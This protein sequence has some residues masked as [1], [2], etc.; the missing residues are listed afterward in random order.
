VLPN[1]VYPKH[2]SWALRHRSKKCYTGVYA[3]ALVVPDKKNEKAIL[4]ASAIVAAGSNQRFIEEFGF[5]E[6]VAEIRKSLKSGR[7]DELSGKRDFLLDRFAIYGEIDD[8]RSRIDEYRKMGIDQVILGSPF[9]YSLEA[10]E[11]L[12]DL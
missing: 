7:Y 2:V 3:P 12:L 6:E 8:L 11:A 10:I 1:Y 5:E 4:I 9:T